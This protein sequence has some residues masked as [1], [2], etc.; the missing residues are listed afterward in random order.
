[1]C[2]G[3]DV[4]IP[5][6]AVLWTV[7]RDVLSSAGAALG[8]P[9]FSKKRRRLTFI[10]RRQAHLRCICYFGEMTTYDVLPPR[11]RSRSKG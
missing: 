8:W 4:V 2:S 1:M 3:E 7:V 10:S 5:N 11:L 9:P 6:P